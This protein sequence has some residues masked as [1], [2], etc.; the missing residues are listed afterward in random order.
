MKILYTFLVLSLI[1]SAC[2]EDDEEPTNNNLPLIIGAW[3]INT[4]IFESDT[5]SSTFLAEDVNLPSSLEFFADDMLYETLSNEV[6]ASK[7]I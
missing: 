3:T 4:V 7:V 2:K 1:F 5:S 6:E